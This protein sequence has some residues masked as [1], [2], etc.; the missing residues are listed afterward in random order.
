MS[1]AHGERH[2]AISSA[3]AMGKRHDDLFGHV[4]IYRRILWYHRKIIL[5]NLIPMTSNV[6]VNLMVSL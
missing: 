6:P 1:F 3:M 4:C 5:K 2:L